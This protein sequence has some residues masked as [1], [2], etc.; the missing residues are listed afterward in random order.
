ML[1]ADD[2]NAVLQEI[3]AWQEIDRLVQ[4][5]NGEKATLAWIAAHIGA[6]RIVTLLVTRGADVEFKANGITL[7][8]LGMLKPQILKAIAAAGVKL[9][10]HELICLLCS[11]LPPDIPTD[12]NYDLLCEAARIMLKIRLEK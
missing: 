4:P 2:A 12:Q 1:H 5:L 11:E 8:G 6:E 3:C 9:M 10:P 7:R